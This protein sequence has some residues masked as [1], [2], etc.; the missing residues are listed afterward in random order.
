MMG[1]TMIIYYYLAEGYEYKTAEQLILVDDEEDDNDGE[2]NGLMEDNSRTGIL[3]QS[4]LSGSNTNTNNPILKQSN[5]KASSLSGN[6]SR[7][8][9]AYNEA[10]R[11]S[12]VSPMVRMSTTD[13]DAN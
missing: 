12:F 8:S 10:D 4:H 11:V 13:K 3:S 9:E 5:E 7:Y 1:G 6:G 2:G